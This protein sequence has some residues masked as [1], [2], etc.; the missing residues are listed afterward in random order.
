MLSAILSK[1]ALA[2]KKYQ[3]IKHTSTNIPPCVNNHLCI[4]KMLSHPVTHKLLHI[5]RKPIASCS[6]Y[7]RFYFKIS[8]LTSNSK[9]DI[10]LSSPPRPR[11]LFQSISSFVFLSAHSFYGLSFT[12]SAFLSPPS[13]PPCLLSPTFISFFP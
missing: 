6:I 10:D 3:S 7:C 8:I 13:S 9:S 1:I 2:V 5:E 12:L 4:T 11:R